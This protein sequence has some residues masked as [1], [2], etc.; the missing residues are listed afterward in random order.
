MSFSILISRLLSILAYVFAFVCRVLE[1]KFSRMARDDW[2]A[3]RHI[4]ERAIP[5]CKREAK[6]SVSTSTTS[7]IFRIG[8]LPRF[9]PVK[10]GSPLQYITQWPKDVLNRRFT[11]QLLQMTG[12]SGCPE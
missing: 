12:S 7:F 8:R 6:I 3:S 1:A 9:N 11:G 2:P 10:W 4:E 5:E